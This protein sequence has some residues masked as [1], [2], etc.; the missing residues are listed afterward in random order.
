MLRDME[1]ISISLFLNTQYL[2]E[3]KCHGVALAIGELLVTC[4]TR[5]K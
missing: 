5:T 2:S 1:P 3:P 4:I